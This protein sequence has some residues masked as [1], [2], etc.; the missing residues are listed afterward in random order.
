[1]V[2]IDERKDLYPWS[3]L[4]EVEGNPY[5]A[6]EKIRDIYKNASGGLDFDGTF[7]DEQ[8]QKSFEA[9]LRTTKIVSIFAGIAILI[10]MLGLLAMSTY[11][12]QQRSQ[13]VAIRKV[14]GSDNRGVLLRLISSFLIYVGVAF[15]I[16]TPV[17]WYFMN[18]W[19]SDYSYRI[20]LNPL[21]FVTAGVFCLFISFVT[22][23][24]Q[25]HRA[26]NA[27]PV[28]SIANK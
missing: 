6:F 12:I 26:A 13:E 22:V 8:V 19:L 24:F 27:N 17:I 11:F 18:Q 7:L 10:S 25:S 1:M 14:F 9:E 2:R 21:I 4:V 15:I 16:A 3:V 20:S 23:F 5:T 28:D